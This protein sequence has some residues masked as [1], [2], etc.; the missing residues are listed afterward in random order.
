[1]NQKAVLGSLELLLFCFVITVFPGHA[2]SITWTN[3]SSGGWNSAA[4]WS[5]N[6]VPGSADT[7]IITNAGV[8]VSLNG[9]T[10]VGAIVLGASRGG[11]ATLSLAN[12]TLALNGPLTVNSSGSF[13]VDGGELA[14]NNGAAVLNGTVGW[15]AGILG[16][17]LTLSSGSTLNITTANGHNMPDCTFTNNGTVAWTNGTIQ[18]GGIPG[19]SIY[20]Y[21]LWNAQSDQTWDNYYG[22]SGTVFNNYGTFRKSGGSGEFAGDTLF[23][24]GVV[25]NQ[26]AGVIDVQNGA[27][28]LQL[29]FQG[30]GSFTGGFITTNQ[31]GLTVLSVGDFNLNGTVTGTNTWEDAGNLAGTIV[32]NGALTWVGGNWNSASTVTISPNSTVIVAGGAGNGM[33]MSDCTVT[34]NG[35]VL[36]ASGIIQG[37]GIP[38]TS[39]Y[40]YGLW[41]AQSDQTLNDYYGY[42]G[43]VF[44]NYGTLRKSGGASE[45]TNAT[46]FASGVFFNQIA[47]M[48]DVQNGTNGLQLAFQGGGNFTGGYIT[49]NQSG[50]TVLS[51]GNFNLNGAVLGTN[52][53]EDQGNLVGANVIDGVLTWIAGN[54]NSATSVTINSNSTVIVAGG[55]GNGMNMSDCS[56]INKGTVL[57]ASGIIQ[58]GG[59]P[60][61]YIYNYGLWNAQS[62]QTLNNYYG[63]SG[64]VFNNYGTL[65][66]SGGASE[67]A[68]A[69]VF[70]GVVINQLA[71]VIDVQNGT[72][73]LQLAF[74][75]GGSFTGGYITSNQFGL[76]VLSQGNFNLNGTVLGTNVWEDQGNLVGNNVIVGALTWIAGNWNSAATVTI[77]SNS[78]VIVAG[79]AG[80]GM[81]MADCTVTNYGTVLWA[82]GIIQGGGIPGTYIYNYGLWNAQSDQTLDNYYGYN[83]TVFNNYGTLR[84]SGGASEFD[85]A[86]VF[87]G[88]VINQLAG[89]I[90]VQNGTNGLQLAF[91]GGG[92]FTGG[93]ITS[94]QFGLTTLEAANYNINGTVI[95]TNIWETDNGNL[96]G[97]N[98]IVGALTWISG[99]W[100][101]TTSVTISPNSTLIVAGGAGNGMDMANCIVTNKGTVLWSSG[102]L[103]GGGIPGTSIYNYGLWNA[104]SDQ[105]LDNYYGYNGTVFKNS[106]IFRKTGSTNTTSLSV[107]FT[108]QGGAMEA[109]S[110]TI[111]LGSSYSQGGG[112]LTIDLGGTNSGQSGQISDSSVVSLGGPFNL[113]L[114]NG[115]VPVVGNQFRI[116]SCSSLSGT[117]TS[118]N[119]PGGMAVVYTNNGVLVVVTNTVTGPFLSWTAPAPIVYG[120]ALSSNQLN[121]TASVPGT[122]AY[123]PSNGTVL[124]SGLYTLSVTFSPSNAPQSIQSYS[125]NLFVSPASLTVAAS[126]AARFVGQAN[127]VFTGTISG[128]VNG[129]NITAAYSCSATLTSPFGIYPIVPTLVDPG[130][131]ETNYSVSLIDGTLTIVAQDYNSLVL[132]TPNL[133][134]YWP[135]TSASQANSAVNG[136]TGTFVAAAA[137]GPP[138]S[139]PPLFNMPSN[140][141]V[142]LDGNGS[143]VNTSLSGGLTNNQGSMIGW[144]NLSVLPSTTGRSFII[145]GES[146]VGND[147]DL[148]IQDDNQIYFYTDSDGA[149]S[150]ASPLTTSN[151]GQWHFVA[152]TFTASVSRNI[153][154]D[155]VLVA[156]STPGPHNPAGIGTFAMGES[157][158]FAGRFFEGS[159][160][161]AAVF[162]RQ[163]T[164]NEVANLYAVAVSGTP[165]DGDQPVGMPSLPLPVIT[166]VNNQFLV[167][168]QTLIFT[169]TAVVATL[170]VTFSLGAPSPEGAAITTN[171][172]FTWTP[173]C[174]EGSSS[175]GITIWATDGGTPPLSNA[176]VFAVTVGDCVQLGLGSAVAQIGQSNG[177]AVN[178]FS[179]VGITNLSFALS[180]TANRLTHFAFLASNGAIASATVQAMGSSAPVF[181]LLS[182]PGQTLPTHSLLGTISFTV[183]PGDSI[184]LPV[185]ATNITGYQ[186]GGAVVGNVTSLPGR[187][188]VIGLHPLLSAAPG[189]D[190]MV[191]LTLF[192]NPGSNY[193]I[194]F[195]TN[196]ATTN[197]QLGPDVL[198]SNLQQ[199][200]SV[201]ATNARMFFRIQ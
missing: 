158:V 159:L 31:Y 74:Q 49:S 154:L 17:V 29:D 161:D 73:G 193:Q 48:I 181:T 57:W 19:T 61:T 151:L 34:N 185:A 145:A 95:G 201:N 33:N 53:W 60:G 8:T 16:G 103:Q 132:G 133:L 135:F 198:L 171:G 7:A 85:N 157:D 70:S 76:T 52:I 148:Q 127:P 190:S 86:T 39:I 186:T 196:L 108:N 176:I 129:D 22:Y 97:N 120:T 91:Q 75:G 140:T 178:L 160:A 163:L 114:A 43:T 116:L 28:G 69:T 63:Y 142:V 12:Q 112:G 169:N 35:T 64:T 87:S 94:N 192:G 144:F 93:Y 106:G 168:G 3:T 99:N 46:I 23:A 121:A 5:P 79:G 123:T 113:G 59:I 180:A 90:D 199:N 1:M 88:V 26:L 81:N 182:E 15:S 38:G 62:D 105:T 9:G 137:V 184:F 194:G 92:N 68:N 126:N 54:W 32:I 174:E 27:N 11:T 117:F 67:L 44:N 58:G 2:A 130:N 56:V 109:D 149:T 155:G 170:P 110:G 72:N 189:G 138:G 136:Y 111:S 84:K 45:L 66:K 6:Q 25:F 78:T 152:A 80:N 156:S 30:G 187:I 71:G 40:N 131:R 20:N 153:Y 195:N 47:G 119:I 139:G 150:Y 143:F 162:N 50:L 55:T 51:Q 122:F 165:I 14:G 13:T 36:W 175:N 21:G 96:I 200:I 4:N 128:L 134:G 141:A 164:S 24:S 197:W 89:V 179:T 147:F 146:Q 107:T 83:G 115:F 18:G 77:N 10:T 167:V 166:Q 188:T 100:N 41:N 102:Y 104:Q 42:S 101:N 172:V 183:L 98:V 173:T 118:T 124:N 37:G 65:R 191:T 125:V 82:S 177:I